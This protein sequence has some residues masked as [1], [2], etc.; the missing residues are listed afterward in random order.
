MNR[1]TKLIVLS[2]III[3]G[4]G[5]Q[6]AEPTQT[7]TALPMSILPNML[8]LVLGPPGSPNLVFGSGNESMRSEVFNFDDACSLARL[9]WHYMPNSNSHSFQLVLKD[10]E[11]QHHAHWTGN[12]NPAKIGNE[13]IALNRPMYLDIEAD[14]V[15]W[16][17]RVMC[18]AP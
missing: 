12:H 18:V 10:G 17:L 7:P 15:D 3:L 2:L 1:F 4:A 5:C 9:E 13:D 14:G 6:A 11:Y 8:G 16:E